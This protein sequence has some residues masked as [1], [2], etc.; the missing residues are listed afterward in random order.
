MRSI[1]NFP[2]DECI[3]INCCTS[4]KCELNTGSLPHEYYKN[5]INKALEAKLHFSNVFLLYWFRISIVV[6]TLVCNCI[7]V[8]NLWFVN[9]GEKTSFCHHLT[10]SIENIL[11]ITKCAFFFS[12]SFISVSSGKSTHINYIPSAK[13]CKWSQ[14]FQQLSLTL[15]CCCIQMFVS[16]IKILQFENVKGQLFWP[17]VHLHTHPTKQNFRYNTFLFTIYYSKV[18]KK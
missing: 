16:H 15:Y 14:S 4:N 13:Y 7:H 18:I 8:L 2:L 5:Q 12:K 11:G 3:F 10:F 9:A 1:Y 17:I 6:K